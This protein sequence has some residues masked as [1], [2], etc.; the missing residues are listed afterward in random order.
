VVNVY[1]EHVAWLCATS[2]TLDDEVAQHAQDALDQVERTM[3]PTYPNSAKL[4]VAGR[5]GLDF[6]PVSR[7]NSV[8]ADPATVR[9]IAHTFDSARLPALGRI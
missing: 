3:G 5:T 4:L 9:E 2:L 7:W 8:L 1:P 6:L